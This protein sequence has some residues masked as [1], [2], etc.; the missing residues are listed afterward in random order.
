MPTHNLVHTLPCAI[1]Y[2][3]VH[4]VYCTYHSLS[5]TYSP[6]G[7]SDVTFKFLLKSHGYN[8]RPWVT[9][10]TAMFHQCYGN[11]PDTFC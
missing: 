3:S 2:N 8:H 7:V 10:F 4:T 5:H 1:Q 11:M 9:C 6:A